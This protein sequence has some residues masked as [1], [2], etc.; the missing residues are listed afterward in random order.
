LKKEPKQGASTTADL[1]KQKPQEEVLESKPSTFSSDEE[2]L[3]AG[4]STIGMQASRLSGAQR[5]KL[6]RERKMEEGTWMVEK[7][8]RKTPPSQDKGTVGSSWGLKRPHSDLSTP[9]QEKQQPKKPRCRLEHT[10]KL[11]LESRWRL[12]I[13]TI[14]MLTWIRLRL[15]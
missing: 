3:A 12:S 5:K 9:S 15:T 1:L 11:L 6:I 4:I 7:P 2:K 14:L 13:G 10:R 8:K